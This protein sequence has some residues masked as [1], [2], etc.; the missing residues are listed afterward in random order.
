MQ[1]FVT[2]SQRIRKYAVE[3][4]VKGAELSRLC[5]CRQLLRR[6]DIDDTEKSCRRFEIAVLYAA[7]AA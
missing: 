4:Q 3:L 6:G 7:G 5:C 1:G 2:G